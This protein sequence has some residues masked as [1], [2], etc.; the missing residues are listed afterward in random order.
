MRYHWLYALSFLTVTP[1]AD[2]TTPLAP[3]GDVRVKHAWSSIPANWDTLSCPSTGTTIDLY[4]ALNPHHDNALIDALYQVADLVRP[5]PDTLELV[6]SWLTHHGVRPSSISTT[7]GS[8]WLTVSNVLV[9]RANEM[10]GASYQLYRHSRVNKTMIRT[11]SYSL[12]EVLYAHIQAVAPTTYFASTRTLRQIPR[13][14]SVEAAAEAA[15]GNPVTVLSSRAGEVMPSQ[16]RWIYKTFAYVPT[17]VDRNTLGVFGFQKDYP[18]KT[19]LTMFMTNFRSDVQ[20]PSLATFAV[21]LVN[22]GAYDPDNPGMEANIDVQYALAMAYPTPI[23]FYISGGTTRWSDSG[24][25]L[26]GDVYLESLEYMLRKPVI[27]QTVSISYGTYEWNV[28][29]DY[30]R[31]LSIMFAQFGARGSDHGVGEDCKDESGTVRFVPEFPASCPY[32]TAVGGTTGYD[33]EVAAPLSGGGFSD[34]FP[35][36]A[37]QDVAVS[38]FLERQGTQYSGL[39]NPEGRG[40]PDIAAQALKLTIFFRKFLTLVEGTSCSAPTVAGIISLL[41]DYLITNG[42]PSLGFLNIRL[43]DDGF[44]GLNDI[45]SGS[46][47]DCGTDGFSAVPGWDPVRP[48]RLVFLH[49]LRWLTCV[50]Y[51]TGLGTPD[52]EKLQNIFMAPLEGGTEQGNQDKNGGPGKWQ[53]SASPTSKLHTQVDSRRKGN[54]FP[55]TRVTF[56]SQLQQQNIQR[57]HTRL[58]LSVNETGRGRCRQSRIGRNLVQYNSDLIPCTTQSAHTHATQSLR[59]SPFPSAPC[60]SCFPALGLL[61]Q[62]LASGPASKIYITDSAE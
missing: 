45:T 37:Y 2:F 30:A 13:T 57:P 61:P 53:R 6:T 38:A 56:T 54:I 43:Y 35:R 26:H 5:H 49:F 33:P 11:V 17:A 34:Y 58:A 7:H 41:N 4:I 24:E 44:A 27:P 40:I 42:R 19:D 15:S 55:S 59:L 20:S 48:A 23:I 39:Y 31:A 36:P 46:N 8:A 60:V 3:W 28:P 14:R 10:L 22:G 16:L 29:R 21:E 47:P 1:L 18:S 32:L 12:P 62:G 25:P 9:S 51:V 50:G 52:F